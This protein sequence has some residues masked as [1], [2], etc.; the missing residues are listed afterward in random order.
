[1][2][3]KGASFFLAPLSI[4]M[5]QLMIRTDAQNLFASYKP[6]HWSQICRLYTCELQLRLFD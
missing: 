6:M 2:P 1:M 4:E 3:L 5:L